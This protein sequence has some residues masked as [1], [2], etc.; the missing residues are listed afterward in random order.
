MNKGNLKTKFN[1]L[2]AIILV[3]TLTG[4]SDYS[5]QAKEKLIREDRSENLVEEENSVTEGDSVK[6]EN[7]AS[8]GDSVNE[9]NSAME[10]NL[11]INPGFEETVTNGGVVLASGWRTWYAP[12]LPALN[13]SIDT[14][15]KHS[16][17]NSIRIRAD[18]SSRGVYRQDI[19]GM[20]GKTYKFSMYVKTENVVPVKSND[21][22]GDVRINFWN[23]SWGDV[24]P[25]IYLTSSTLKGDTDWTLLEKIITIPENAVT[26]GFQCYFGEATGTAWYDDVSLVECEPSKEVPI[27][28]PGFEETYED[29]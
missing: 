26:V 21:K 6:E 22:G 18:K 15:I 14:D 16:G 24:A 11:V 10:E 4:I 1:K 12:G 5:V 23:A 7:S 13:F 27:T 25:G 19:T 8:E 2:L 20:A 29:N 28:N 17:N 3:I 9:E